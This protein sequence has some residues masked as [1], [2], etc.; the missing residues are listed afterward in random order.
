MTR[1]AT[2]WERPARKFLPRSLLGRSLLIIL[3]PLI[4]TQAVRAADFLWQPSGPDLAA[5]V[6]GGG[7]GDRADGAAAAAGGGGGGGAVGAVAWGAAGFRPADA[8][9]PGSAAVA[10]LADQ[11][12]GADGRRPGDRAA[13]AGRAAVH[14]GLD[15]RSA[16]GADRHPV[17]A[18]TVW[19]RGAAC[20][21]AAQAPLYQH[22][23]CL[24]AVARRVLHPAVQHRG[25]VHAQPGARHTQA[26]GGGRGV[27]AGAR[28][29]RDPSGGGDRGAA[30]RRRR[31]TACRSG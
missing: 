22:D 3:V 6:G 8:D 7:G 12:I 29:R 28:Y 1:F 27:R 31:S 19:Q 14:H 26:G 30:G 2:G 13:R 4:A 9:R 20:G 15:R 11:H 23:L 21:G 10:G 18:G 17:A 5:A 24:C 25:A 16:I